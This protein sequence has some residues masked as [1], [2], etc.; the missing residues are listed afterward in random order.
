MMNKHP[1]TQLAET[2]YERFGRNDFAGVLELTSN[3][4]VGTLV[5]FGQTFHGKDGFLQ[6]MHG[7]KDAFP[8]MEIRL[9]NQVISDGQVVN[10]ISA[11]TVHS[12]PLQTPNGV[13]PATGKTVHF[14]VCEVWGI[15]DGKLASLRNYQDALGLMAQLGLLPESEAVGL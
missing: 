1:Y 8:E 5:P 10:E 9:D 2:I 4:W 3:D 11:T 6:F 7:F 12:G 14:T 15:K 13:V